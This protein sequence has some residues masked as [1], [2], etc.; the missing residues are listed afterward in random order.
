MFIYTLHCRGCKPN[1]YKRNQGASPTKCMHKE[2][3]APSIMPLTKS[4]PVTS[5]ARGFRLP[6]FHRRMLCSLCLSGQ[7]IQGSDHTEGNYEGKG[8][9]IQEHW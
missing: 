2:Q 8:V 4:A 3:V 1:V 6:E 7:Y 9:V 5:I